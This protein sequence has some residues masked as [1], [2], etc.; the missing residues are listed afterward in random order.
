MAHSRNRQRYR[1]RKDI[2]RAATRLAKTGG[3]PTMDSVAEEALVSRATLYRY[4]PNME[5]LLVEASLDIEVPSPDEL[6]ANET[7]TDPVE[8]VDKAE[9]AVHKMIYDNEQ[10]LRHMLSGAVILAGKAQTSD[11]LVRQNRRT[12]LIEAA[13]APV[14]DQ[15]KK[16]DYD[17]LCASLALVFGPESMIVYKDILHLSP[18]KA[19]G[20]KRWMLQTLI[21]AT[22]NE[23]TG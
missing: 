5:A 13:L 19:R 16:S 3:K 1:T 21:Q 22:L 7:E 9:M 10:A 6:F 11:T 15:M 18:Q 20:I 2:L 8:R 23:S 12:P 4:F 14:R 17:R